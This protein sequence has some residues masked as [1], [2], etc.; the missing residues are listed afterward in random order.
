MSR[1]S[2]VHKESRGGSLSCW[3]FDFWYGIAICP[4][5]AVAAVKFFLR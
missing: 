5:L 1:M 4:M 3:L 2:T